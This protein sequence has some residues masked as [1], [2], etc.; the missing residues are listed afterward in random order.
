MCIID[1]EEIIGYLLTLSKDIDELIEPFLFTN[2]IVRDTFQGK[3]KIFVKK[4]DDPE[5]NDHFIS[6]D[7]RQNSYPE[8]FIEQIWKVRDIFSEHF[9]NNDWIL[10]STDF[11]PL[12]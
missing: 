3:I 1:E 7:I 4:Y 8:N 11:H 5:T 2:K 12:S 6:I 10:I 9:Q